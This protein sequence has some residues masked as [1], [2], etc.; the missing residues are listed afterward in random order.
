MA[1]KRP[2]RFEPRSHGAQWAVW[3]LLKDRWYE[4]QGEPLLDW[5]HKD[6]EKRCQ[7]LQRLFEFANPLPFLDENESGPEFMDPDYLFKK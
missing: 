2:L 5:F 3:D 7:N 4:P 1:G 6:C